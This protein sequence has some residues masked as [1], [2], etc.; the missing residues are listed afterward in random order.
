MGTG[1]DVKKTQ[2]VTFFVEVYPGYK[3]ENLVATTMNRDQIQR[4]EG[5]RRL[6]FT[7]ELPHP[8]H[9]L[10]VDGTVSATEVTDAARGTT[11]G[12]V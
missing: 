11:V 5:H 10:P 12:K 3:T 7:V 8:E 6:A 4:V 9:M 2:Q 1:E